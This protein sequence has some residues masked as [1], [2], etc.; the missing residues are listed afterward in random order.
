MAGINS[1]LAFAAGSAVLL[2]FSRK[3]MRNPA[4]HGFWRFFAF[5]T[6]LLLII[7]TA[8]AWFRDPFSPRQVVSWVLLAISA[9]LALAGWSSLGTRGL[10]R[11]NFER[12]T[13]LVANGIFKRIRHPMYASLICF[14]WGAFSK[15]F[16]PAGASLA[17]AAT[18]LTV[19]TAKAEE[20]E[21]RAK[22]GRRYL[23]YMRRTRMFVPFVV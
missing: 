4:S 17:A 14:S 19:M 6:I 12:T 3:S 21:N 10:P 13:R 15:E 2:W 5:E 18:I 8:G 23:E 7:I 16:S 11:G 20:R 9:W 22:F 1:W